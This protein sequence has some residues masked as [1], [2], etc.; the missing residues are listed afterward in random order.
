MKLYTVT[1]IAPSGPSYGGTRLVAICTDKKA[2]VSLIL[3]NACDMYE[4]SYTYAIVEEVES[5]AMY[6]AIGFETAL[7]FKWEGTYET[8][9][10]LPSETPKEFLRTIGFYEA[11]PI[12]NALIELRTDKR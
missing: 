5:D 6:G 9:R 3:R 2:A 10:Y 12:R 8:G 11:G 7:W 1:T 4:T